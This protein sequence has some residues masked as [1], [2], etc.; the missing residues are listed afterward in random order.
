MQEKINTKKIVELFDHRLKD[1]VFSS[2]WQNNTYIA[3]I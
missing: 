2:E 1:D 3:K